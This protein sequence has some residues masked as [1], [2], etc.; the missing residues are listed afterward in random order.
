VRPADEYLFEVSYGQARAID[1]AELYETAGVGGRWLIDPK[2]EVEAR[3]SRDLRVGESLLTEFVLRRFSH[4]FV[5]DLIF[6]DRAGEG[7]T[8]IGLSFKP[9]LG[10]TRSRL[11]LLDRR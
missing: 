6:Q 7:G 8:T 4:D 3:Y 1:R 9:L 11:G 5:L 2:W 10:W